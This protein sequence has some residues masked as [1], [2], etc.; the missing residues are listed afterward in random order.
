M[1]SVSFV[2][3]DQRLG[4]ELAAQLEPDREAE[5]AGDDSRARS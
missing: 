2:W 3:S 1:S 5:P 4:G